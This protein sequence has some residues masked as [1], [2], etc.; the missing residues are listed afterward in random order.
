MPPAPYSDA[1]TS[2]EDP[3]GLSI[4]L[5]DDDEWEIV[6]WLWQAFRHD[7]A[8]IVNGLPYADGRYQA[9]QLKNY[10]SADGAGY[11]AR[12]P[13]PNTG[14]SAPVGFAIVD[15]LTGDKRSI[16]G[17]WVAP[18][19]RRDGVGRALAIDVLGRHP[20][21]WSIGFQHDNTGAAIFWRAVAD[22]AFGPSRW[23]E[24]THPVPGKPH[25]P[26]DHF[27]ESAS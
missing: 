18:A 10:P 20:G 7:L 12:R 22:A 19:A 3:A 16:T 15:G 6:A 17:F 9:R 27:I 25:V 5:V 14:E 1:V 26:P 4:R 8:L 24:T 2:D 23:T 11:L 13:H 21:P